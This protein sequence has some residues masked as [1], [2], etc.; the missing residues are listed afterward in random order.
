MR[1]NP[2]VINRVLFFLDYCWHRIIPKLSFT[3][4]FYFGLTKGQNRA[5]TRVEV[6]GG[7]TVPGLMCFTR[8]LYTESFT[9]LPRR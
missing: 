6:L 8:R 5:L 9:S 1:Q 2:V 3:R 7:C 4:D